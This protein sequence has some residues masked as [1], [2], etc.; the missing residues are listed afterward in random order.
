MKVNVLMGVPLIKFVRFLLKLVFFHCTHGSALFTR[1]RTQ[2][3]GSVTLVAV[4]DEQRIESIM[5]DSS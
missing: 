2:A 4:Q 3:L 5:E 1:G